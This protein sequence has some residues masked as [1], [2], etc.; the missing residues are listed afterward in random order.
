M[1][2][3]RCFISSWSSSSERAAFEPWESAQ[4]LLDTASRQPDD[5]I[6]EDGD[7]VTALV[8]DV[9]GSATSPTKLRV[10]ALRKRENRPLQYSPG[11]P[12]SPI[13]LPSGYY[14]AD[15]THVILWPDGFATQDF[16]SDAPRLSRLATYLR[17]QL[18][19]QVYFESLFDPSIIARLAE[20]R[21]Q[22]RSVDVALTSPSRDTSMNDAVF[23]NLIPAAFGD[24]AP[25]ISIRLGMGRY[26]PRTRYLSDEVQE[27]IIQVAERA[28]ELV[29]RMI[30]VGRSRET[31]RNITLN[32][33]NERLGDDLQLR[34]SADD[35]SLPDTGHTFEE[36]QRVFD[37]A[38]ADGRLDDAI[39]AQAVSGK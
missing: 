22:I 16:H 4:R 9:V 18:E 24:R 12:L 33:L 39:R 29:D 19:A 1:L 21:G 17:K 23:A 2:D 32:L 8:V 5:L 15:I 35:S 28:S 20:I 6:L 25:S 14:T 7:S 10:L 38:R 27:S 11:Q 26:G 30:I 13:N 34:Q 3:R 36:L 31:D 37:E